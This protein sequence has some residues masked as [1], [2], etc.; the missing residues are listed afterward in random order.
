MDACTDRAAPSSAAPW[1]EVWG[2]SVLSP[3][4]VTAQQ[5]SRR[6]WLHTSFLPVANVKCCL[7]YFSD[8]MA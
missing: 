4:G 5:P 3:G 7:S 2:G 6:N 8:R 1:A